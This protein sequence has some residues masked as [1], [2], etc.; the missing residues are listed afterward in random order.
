MRVRSAARRLTAQRQK[1]GDRAAWNELQ[2]RVRSSED[3]VAHLER[4]LSSNRRI[5]IAVGILMC[6]RQL[7]PDQAV[8]LLKTHSQHHNVKVRDLAEKVIGN[9]T[10]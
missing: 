3:T 9:G 2:E 7:T 4:A 6:Q 5:G 1:D 10:L 8:A